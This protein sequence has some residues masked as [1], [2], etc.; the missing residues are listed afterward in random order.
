MGITVGIDLGTTNSAICVKKIDV[1]VIRNAEGDE[2]TPSCITAMLPE[3]THEVDFIVGRPARDLLKQCPDQTILSVKRLI[4]RDFEEKEVQ[5][6]IHDQGIAYQIVTDPTEPGS[7][8]IP[9]GG[10]MQTPEILSGH[11]LKKLIT[12]AEAVLQGKVD[13][14][15]VTVPAYFSDSQKFATRAACDYAGLKLLRLLPEPTAAALSFCLDIDKASASTMMVF[16]LGGGTF[17]ISILSHMQGSFMEVSKGGDMWLGGDDF[18]QLIVE[19]VY[20]ETEKRADCGAISHLVQQLPIAERLRFLVELKEKAEAAKIALSH[21]DEANIELFGLLKDKAGTLIDIDVTISR[22]QFDALLAPTAE[23]I[24]TITEQMLHE[25]RFEPDLIDR[26]L[27]VGGSSHIPL[28]QNTL[29]ALFGPDKILMHPRPMLAVAEGAALMAAKL[30]GETAVDAEASFAMMHA[31]AHDYYLQLVDGNRHLLI[32]RNTPLPI[33][34]EEKLTF[35]HHEQLLARL[36]VLNEVD[37]LLETVGELWFHPEIP[38][39]QKEKTPKPPEIMLQFTVDEDNIITMKTWS[40]D[41]QE[42]MME[43]KI[44]RGGLATKLYNDLERML[45]SIVATSTDRK[46]ER[47]ILRLSRYVASTILGA[48]NP[49]TGETCEVHKKKAQNQIVLL[50]TCQEKNLAP[51]ALYDFA[52]R[53]QQST[54]QVLAINEAQKLTQLLEALESAI[55]R[56][57][58]I[59]QLE[60]LQTEIEQFYEKVPIAPEIGEADHLADYFDKSDPSDAKNIRKRIAAIKQ[61]YKHQDTQRQVKAERELRQY[62]R[63][64]F[65]WGDNKPIGRFDRDVR[66]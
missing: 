28:I 16:D 33:T 53:V 3:D 18:D 65:D 57:D 8:R 7:I 62:I 29:K 34:V 25:I 24:R 4:G 49:V 66:L 43:A 56:L 63:E 60:H 47:D 14:A 9:L 21:H 58:D 5:A 13:Q 37:G 26:V 1:S 31:T 51:L 27:M 11:I 35:A 50:Q 52:L 42:A 46:I 19:Y 40:L 12:D 41:R 44:A 38:D 64:R 17:D 30:S 23:R 55:E 15:V 59:E 20:T 48:S 39:R 32:A 6:M 61:A 54:G 45:S 22:E 10:Q 36:R 2:L